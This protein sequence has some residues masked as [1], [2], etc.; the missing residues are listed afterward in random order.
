MDKAIAGI[1]ETAA[2]KGIVSLIDAAAVYDRDTPA[3]TV[4]RPRFDLFA[5]TDAD[6]TD[7]QAAYMAKLFKGQGNAPGEVR[8]QVNAAL[9]VVRQNRAA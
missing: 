9:A 4:E 7:D 1:K 3:P 2:K 5:M 8:K 6:P